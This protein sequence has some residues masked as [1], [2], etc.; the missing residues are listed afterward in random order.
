MSDFRGFRFGNIHIKDLHLTVVSS[1][2]R[3]NKNLLPDP[4]DYSVDVPGGN[5]KYYFGQTHGTRSF[6]ITT[7]FDNLDEYTIRKIRQI[8]VTD[9]LKDL[10]FDEEPYKVYRAK[11]SNAPQF[12]YVC[13]LDKETNQRVYKG[14][15]NFNFICYH[16]YAFCFNK[17]IVT[18]A[19]Y[20]K[21]TPPE[22]IIHPTED[23]YMLNDDF[24]P[25]VNKTIK[26]RYNIENNMQTPWKGGYPTIEQVQNGELF[27]NKGKDQDNKDIANIINVRNYWNN[28]PRWQTAAKLLTTP[29]LDYDQELI[30]MPQ[31]SK[32]RYYNMD[33]GMD[34]KNSALGSRLL[35]Y[36]P[37]DISIDFKLHL[38]NLSNSFRELGDYTFR[39]SRY[40]VQ[41]LTIDQAVDWI[42]LK[43]FKAEDNDAYKYSNRYFKI[44]NTR[45]ENKNLAD[46]NFSSETRSAAQE[47]T[48]NE[49][50]NEMMD[51]LYTDLTYSHPTHCY[52]AEPIPQEKLSY[53]I[54]LFYKQSNLLIDQYRDNETYAHIFNHKQGEQ[55]AKFY[56]EQREMCVTDDERNELYWRMLKEAILDRYK[57]YDEKI[58]GLFD[59]NYTYE[60]FV[61]DFINNPQEYI[62]QT[63][64]LNYGEFNFNITRLPQF[65]TFDYFDITNENFD[66]IKWEDC[67]CYNKKEEEIESKRTTIKTLTLDSESRLLYNKKELE[68]EENNE[69]LEKNFFKVEQVKQNFNDNIKRG[70]WF[71]L[72]PGWSLIDVSPIVDENV[73]GG[74]RWKDA[75]PFKWGVP[76]GENQEGQVIR[77]NYDKIYYRAIERFIKD[78]HPERKG[79]NNYPATDSEDWENYI[80]FRLWEGNNIDYEDYL[81]RKLPDSYA[82]DKLTTNVYNNLIKYSIKKYRIEKYETEFLKFLNDCFAYFG[83]DINDWWWNSNN[84]MWINYPPLYW[85]FVDLLNKAKIEYVP[86]YY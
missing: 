38:G 16:P 77:N 52:I 6:S 85:G 70:H 2:D 67:G 20:Y 26:D 45:K 68:W 37:G 30:Y 86:Q 15:C 43:T 53:F 9:K 24:V 41:R 34:I 32:I 65:Y 17:Y 39:I 1:G 40:N 48:D 80:K 7:A 63:D 21:C 10:V 71:Q 58:Y 44:L 27:Y 72:P 19:D 18:A 66:K 54:R 4:T 56:E 25:P 74:K 79:S 59:D 28:V 5:G 82:K 69:E 8:F 13:F 75:R 55:Y 51:N 47:K 33:M 57:D 61:Y 12:N 50:L 60:D 31:Y 78:L 64:D 3:F 11:L 84:Y 14:E 29:T 36:N 35:I 81:D 22:L 49:L 46:L 23:T 62:R 73:W 76:G 83:V 42:G